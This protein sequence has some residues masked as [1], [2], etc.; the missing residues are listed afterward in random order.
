MFNRALYLNQPEVLRYFEYFLLKTLQWSISENK[1]FKND[2]S[3]LK[4]QKLLFFTTAINCKASVNKSALIHNVFSN[5]KAY[6]YGPVE[7]NVYNLLK[8][9]NNELS[10]IKL[11][12]KSLDLKFDLGNLES[13]ISA[14]ESVNELDKTVLGIIRS[15]IEDLKSKN[16]N[17]IKYT[18]FNLVE[19]SHRWRCWNYSYSQGNRTDIRSKSIEEESMIFSL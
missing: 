8:G 5:F 7:E 10:H 16:K 4:C 15:A 17:L 9:N 3:V 12:F 14:M 2:L 13:S 11:T 18:P 1:N 6:Q 19:L